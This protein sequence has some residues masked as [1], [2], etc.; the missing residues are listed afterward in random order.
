MSLQKRTKAPEVSNLGPDSGSRTRATAGGCHAGATVWLRVTDAHTQGGGPSHRH[1]RGD[2]KLLPP[3]HAR[4]RPQG[5][6]PCQP[7]RGMAGWS[8]AGH[9]GGA[10]AGRGWAPGGHSG[11][12]P[13]ATAAA[14]QHPECGRVSPSC[15]LSVHPGSMLRKRPGGHFQGH[16]R[17]PTQAR[18]PGRGPQ[19]PL[20]FGGWRIRNSVCMV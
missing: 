14:S 9:W 15:S 3:L 12:G 4:P 5:R 18:I 7:R 1:A 10:Q 17:H 11:P 16:G 13:K 20:R 8:P 2:R 6:A 19:K